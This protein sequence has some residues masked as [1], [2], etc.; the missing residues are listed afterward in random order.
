LDLFPGAPH[1][2][3]GNGDDEGERIETFEKCSILF[4]LKED[5]NFK[6]RNTSSISRLK[7]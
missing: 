1:G 7:I 5:K 2:G 6:C 4:K 3:V